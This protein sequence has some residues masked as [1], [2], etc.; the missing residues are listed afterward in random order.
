M[1]KSQ[2]QFIDRSICINCGSKRLDVLSRGNYNDDPLRTFINE[3]PW[4]EHP[5][6]FLQHEH[7]IFN[8][9]KDCFQTF[10][11]RILSPK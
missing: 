3:D 7:W 1:R 8:R 6:P 5:F 4:G 2:A 9:C 10:H 11:K